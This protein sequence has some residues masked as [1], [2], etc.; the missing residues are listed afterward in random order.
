MR[1][2][3]AAMR[4]RAFVQGLGWGGPVWT[5]TG[6]MLDVSHEQ[7]ALIAEAEAAMTPKWRPMSTAP[8]SGQGPYGPWLLVH[9][10]S[11]YSTVRRFWG[12]EQGLKLWID[13]YGNTV[14]EHAM[15]G[16]LPIPSEG[17]A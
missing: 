11:D 12:E 16:W 15:N 6:A 5:L 3:C 9:H 13:G 10:N 17:D 1:E 14:D 2:A 8:R 7:Y 4:R